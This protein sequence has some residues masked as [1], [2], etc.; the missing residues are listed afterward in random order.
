M[1]RKC[2]FGKFC[3]KGTDG[4]T[5]FT[6]VKCNRKILLKLDINYSKLHDYVNYLIDKPK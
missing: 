5:E 3:T 4:Q 2:W 6:I 1:T